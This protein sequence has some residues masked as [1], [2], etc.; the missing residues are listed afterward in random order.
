MLF[1]SYSHEP[2]KKQFMNHKNEHIAFQW[3]IPKIFENVNTSIDMGFIFYCCD[4]D[5]LLSFI[6]E[7]DGDT[8]LCRVCGDKASGF[9][10]GVHACEGCKVGGLVDLPSF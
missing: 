4:V 3:D 9:H 8:V 2:P 5:V 10:Y 1:P 7:F 6:V